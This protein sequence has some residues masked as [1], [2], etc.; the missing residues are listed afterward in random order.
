[1]SV[2]VSELKKIANRIEELKQKAQALDV[3]AEQ[4]KADLAR[5]CSHPTYEE[6]GSYT[7]RGHEDPGVS[8]TFKRCTICGHKWDLVETVEKRIF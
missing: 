3:E 6:G 7:S 8:W 1:M 4:L 2:N 5:K